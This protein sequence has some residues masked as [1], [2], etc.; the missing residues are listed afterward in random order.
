MLPYHSANAEWYGD[1][2]TI[3]GT[4][5]IVELWYE[6]QQ[7]DAVRV[8]QKVMAEMRRVDQLFSPYIESSELSALNRWASDKDSYAKPLPVSSELFNLLA[9]AQAISRLSDGA[10]DIT[11]A[12]VA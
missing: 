5:V 12:S 9:D 10:F 11:F 4:E 3:M 6:E 1:K 2:Q 7:A 8:I